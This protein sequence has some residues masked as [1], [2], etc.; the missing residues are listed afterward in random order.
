MGG[1]GQEGDRLWLHQE[2]GG[3]VVLELGVAHGDV[4]VA[5]GRVD[6]GDRLAFAQRGNPPAV[7]PNEALQ[8]DLKLM[9]IIE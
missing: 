4:A 9:E 3:G 7:G 6:I 8:F 5:V 2:A 1:A